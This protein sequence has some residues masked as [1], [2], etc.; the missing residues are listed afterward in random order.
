MRRINSGRN[1]AVVYMHP[2]E[3]DPGEFKDCDVEIPF[4]LRVSQGLGRKDVKEKLEKLLTDFEF[5]PIRE[6]VPFDK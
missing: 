6:A 2:Y 3:L 5:K 4:P 1:P